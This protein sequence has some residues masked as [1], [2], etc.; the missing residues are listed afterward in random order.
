VLRANQ[1]RERVRLRVDGGLRSGWEVVTAAMLGAD[2]FG[3]GSIALI[4]EGCIM[5]RVCH[6]NNCP[7]GITSQKETLRKKF[8]GT[9][10]PV[11]EFFLYIAEEVRMTLAQLGYRSVAEVVGRTDLLKSRVIDSGS[12]KAALDLEC[13]LRVPAT[14]ANASMTS[15]LAESDSTL[16]NRILLDADVR[17]AIEHQQIASKSY[18]IINTDRTIGARISGEIARRWGNDGFHGSIDLKFAG[19]AGQSFGAFNIRNV[20]LELTGEANDYVGK[21]M[22]GGRI[23]IKPP[24]GI[25]YDSWQNVLVG[26]TCLYGATGGALY[27]AG[28]AGERFAVRNSGALAVIE[29]AGDHCCEYMT[30]GTVVILGAVGRNF[31]AGMTGGL[32]YVLDEN[33][34]VESLLNGDEGKRLQR[35][36]GAAALSLKRL[37]EEHLSFTGS[38][39]AQ[40]ILENWHEYLPQFWQ[41][42]P[43][44]EL[45][46]PDALPELQTSESLDSLDSL[47]VSIFASMPTFHND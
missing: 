47:D 7:V 15:L 32:A 17:N 5:A 29:G 33:E 35:L 12:R 9:P 19:S 11:V 20:R 16:N 36:S 38:L 23:T 21:G 27:V 8:P 31:A 18:S 25:R 34:L 10:E 46:H 39:R 28:Q 40:M 6:T 1:L 26:N 37:L 41:V 24:P 14:G 42:V 43:L 2:E 22:N 45:Q 44:A 3:F 4:A 30:G 13:L